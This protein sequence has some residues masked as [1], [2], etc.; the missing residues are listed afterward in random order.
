M[1]KKKEEQIIEAIFF[2]CKVANWGKKFSSKKAL[3]EHKRTHRGNRGFTCEVCDQKFTQYSSLQKHGRVHDKQK[4]FKCDFKGCHSAFTQVSNL[5]RH[6]RIHTGEKPYKWDKCK[7]S[8]ASGSNL[9][10]HRNTH[11]SFTRRKVYKCEFCGED[12]TKNYLYQSSLRKHMQLMHKEEYEKLLNEH[13]V[14]KPTVLRSKQGKVFLIEL[15]D[16]DQHKSSTDKRD[17]EDEKEEE[18]EVEELKVQ[19]NQ[20]NQGAK[21]EILNE[22][23][24]A[25]NLIGQRQTRAMS[26][27]NSFVRQSS[28]LSEF[29]QS[30]NLN[31][32]ADLLE[33][34]GFNWGNTK[35]DSFNLNKRGLSKNSSFVSNGAWSKNNSFRIISD[36]KFL[37]QNPDSAILKQAND[38]YFEGIDDDVSVNNFNNQQAGAAQDRGYDFGIREYPRSSFKAFSSIKLDEQPSFLFKKP[39]FH[40]SPS[41]NQ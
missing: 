30:V 10:Q 11:N 28:M 12:E 20:T 19:Q 1:A 32:L 15:V 29:S 38:K 18:D 9:K 24:H 2:E 40:A 39:S 35:Q 41:Q 7:K 6:K 23:E 26:R 21:K 4:P 16:R 5:I 14:D 37:L 25:P 17:S 8:F 31:N 34:A 27:E 33:K 22:T 3:N 13:E 36:P